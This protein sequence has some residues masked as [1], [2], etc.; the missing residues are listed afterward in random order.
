MVE[1]IKLF[2]RWSFK[3]VI[4]SDPGLKDYI[5]LRPIIIPRTNGYLHKLAFY[6]QKINIIERIANR[7]MVS[8][9]K[10]KKH[11]LSSGHNTGKGKK[12]TKV[13]Y[14][15]LEELEKRTKQNPIQV[16]VTALEN[17]APFEEVITI[18]RSGAKY[19]QAVDTSPLRRLN[20]VIRF[21]VQGAHY[22]SFNSNTSFKDSFVEEILDCYNLGGKS[23]AYSKKVEIEKMAASAK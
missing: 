11:F 6:K 14:E 9:H 16:I 7:I 19:A 4:V 1:D 23:F 22:R 2:N 10:G 13:M 21:L 18:E 8:G 15:V 5:N 12:V 17:A 20:L 3:G